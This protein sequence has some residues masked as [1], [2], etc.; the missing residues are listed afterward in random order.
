M[1]EIPDDR[2]LTPAEHTLSRWLLTHGTPAAAQYLADLGAA[3]V[4]SR[5]GCGC[6]SINFAVDGRIAQAAVPFEVLADFQWHD[7]A[8]HL[9]GVF[10]FARGGTLAGL[11]VWSIDGQAAIDRL[12][13]PHTLEPIDRA[14]AT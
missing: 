10:L 14:P 11:E 1:S 4:V 2:P 7:A 3:R 13:L 12:P 5:C 6:A 9:G 8:E